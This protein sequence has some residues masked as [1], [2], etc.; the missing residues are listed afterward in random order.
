MNFIER[1]PTIIRLQWLVWI[2]VVLIIFFSVLPEG[3][4]IHA[5]LYTLINIS[6]YAIVIYGNISFL[7]PL[8]YEKGQ[9]AAYVICV[10]ILVTAAGVSRGYSLTALYNAYYPNMPDKMTVE[11]IIN[12]TVAGLLT[13]MLSFIF[14]MAL[15]YFELKR[16]SEKILVQKSQAELNLLKSQVQ[17]HFLFNTLNNIYYEAYREAPRTAK[18]IERLSDIM[19]YFV[20]ESPKDEVS[21]STE[22]QF[23]ENYMVLEKIRIRHEID[24]D[25]IKECNTEVR[26]PPMLLM[27]FVENIFKHGIDKSSSENKIEL[28]LVQQDGYLLF[29]TKNRIYDLPGAAVHTGFGIKNLRKRLNLLYGDNFELNIINEGNYFTAFLK[30]PLT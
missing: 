16:Q 19:R 22:I 5:C 9:K 12:F 25:F 1:M 4:F 29:Q 28:S 7:F 13:Y 17:P 24:L 26:I 21:L 15:A 11:A 10:V 8:L 27:T 3:G 23:L 14:R 2:A 30:V 6:F 20:D 18:L